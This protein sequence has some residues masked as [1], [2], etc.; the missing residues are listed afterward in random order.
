MKTVQKGLSLMEI[1]ITLVIISIIASVAYPKYERMVA[2]S[3]QTEAKTILQAIYIG[4]DLY[5]TSNQKYAENLSDLD[6]QIPANP[7]YA[8]TLTAN[9]VAET[10]VATAKANI[11]GDVAVDEWQINQSN[12]ITHIVNDAME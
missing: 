1:M 8:Y 5:K 2:K 7:R 4:Q 11:D 9:A 12:Q 3:K 10:F 6:I